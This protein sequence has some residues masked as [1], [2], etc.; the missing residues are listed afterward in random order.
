MKMSLMLRLPYEMY[1]I[2]MK[3]APCT[4][5]YFLSLSISALRDNSISGLTEA[6]FMQDILTVTFHSSTQ[7]PFQT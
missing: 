7:S 5:S 3:S 6:E 4:K 1:I 2:S